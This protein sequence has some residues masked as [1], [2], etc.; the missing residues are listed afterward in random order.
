[1]PATEM[2]SFFANAAAGITRT[3]GKSPQFWRVQSSA[4]HVL[5]T[6]SSPVT[7]AGAFSWLAS[8][9]QEVS[10]SSGSLRGISCTPGAPLS[11]PGSDRREIRYD[12]PTA[13]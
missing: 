12:F 3:I 2:S 13:T 9:H 6:P 10:F 1:M 5:P 7:A 11:R 8:F 4:A